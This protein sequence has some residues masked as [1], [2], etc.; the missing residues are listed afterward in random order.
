MASSELMEIPQPPA[1]PFIGNLLNF[2]RSGPVQGLL[3]LAQQYGS[4]YRLALRGTY[5]V[6][7]SD[8][9]LVNEVCDESRFDKSIAGA[10]SKVR[11]FSGDGALYG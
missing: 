1:K 5:L 3:R 4:I 10:L 6:V 11:R 9:A 2:D 8:H 7:I